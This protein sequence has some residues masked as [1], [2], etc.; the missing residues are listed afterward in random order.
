MLWWSQQSYFLFR[1]TWDFEFLFTSLSIS[2]GLHCAPTSLYPFHIKAKK[3]GDTFSSWELR[4]GGGFLP[5]TFSFIRF[6]NKMCTTFEVHVV[7]LGLVGKY[8]FFS[9]GKMFLE[10]NNPWQINTLSFMVQK[11]HLLHSKII[12]IQCFKHLLHSKTS[13]WPLLWTVWIKWVS[14]CD[15]IRMHTIIQLSITGFLLLWSPY[16]TNG[17]GILFTNIL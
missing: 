9:Y 3:I 7:E 8:S 14:A 15:N 12:V 16:Y 11:P 4:D 1:G 2:P 17:S 10:Y 13:S 5:F 6:Y